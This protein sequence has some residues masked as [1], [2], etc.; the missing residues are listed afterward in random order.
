[1]AALFLAHER[2]DVVPA[3][4][5]ES[6]GQGMQGAIDGVRWRIG[7]HE[8]V[9]GISGDVAASAEDDGVYLGNEG[10]LIAVFRL[11]ESV[12]PEA[13]HAVGTLRDLGVETIIAS[14]D[15]LEAVSA[16]QAALHIDRARAR[17]MPSDKVSLVRD[18][19]GQG[20]RVLVI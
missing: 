18:L 16:A 12:R 5:V 6:E 7:R 17:M 10:G 20:K 4:L 8:Y 19:Q 15:R 3:E 9:S 2:R 11:G 1:L 13:E 14:G